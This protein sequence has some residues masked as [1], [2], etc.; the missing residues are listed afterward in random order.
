MAHERTF[1]TDSAGCHG[2]EQRS[3]DRRPS[4]AAAST[5]AVVA[6]GWE[7]DRGRRP[8]IRTTATASPSFFS[9]RARA[10]GRAAGRGT[11]E[12]GYL[13]TCDGYGVGALREGGEGRHPWNGASSVPLQAGA[14]RRRSTVS[15]LCEP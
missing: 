14:S 2:V 15:R 1:S 10:G 8:K 3:A 9:L 5:A 12:E 11:S 4:R 7:E 6:V 13:T